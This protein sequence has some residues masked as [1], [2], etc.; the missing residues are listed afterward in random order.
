MTNFL[1]FS[2][3]CEAEDLF[4]H[5]GSILVNISKMEAGRKILLDPKRGL[6]KQI[7]PQF[8]STSP[9]RKKGVWWL[10]KWLSWW[11]NKKHFK[12]KWKPALTW[13][14]TKILFSVYLMHW[15]PFF[16]LKKKGLVSQFAISRFNLVFYLNVEGIFSWVSYL[17]CK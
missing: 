16:F 17:C 2:F 14:E 3:E 10:K 1:F 12:K 13:D 4:E 11:F 6:L 15:C 8:D 9:L 5:V 7:I